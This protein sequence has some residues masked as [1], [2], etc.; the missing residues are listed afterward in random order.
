MKSIPSVLVASHLVCG[1]AG[2][3]LGSLLLLQVAYRG[4][5]DHDHE[6]VASLI[7][8]QATALAFQ[9]A[10]AEQALQLLRGSPQHRAESTE[11][12]DEIMINAL[13]E[14]S[15]LGDHSARADTVGRLLQKARLACGR[16]RDRD[17]R[18]QALQARRQSLTV[19]RRRGRPDPS[20]H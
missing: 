1:L 16:S 4:A 17:C 9:F 13:R 11:Q 8:R 15:L 5:P 14:A 3:G 10:P 19:L 12:P 7:Y 2:W 20:D 18:P 6:R